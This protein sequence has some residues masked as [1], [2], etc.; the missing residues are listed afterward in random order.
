MTMKLLLIIISI[1]SLLLANISYGVTDDELRKLIFAAPVFHGLTNEA[2]DK[3]YDEWTAKI[4]E[5]PSITPRV[6]ELL[7][8]ENDED[9]I[10]Y[11]FR[12]LRARGDLKNDALNDLIAEVKAIAESENEPTFRECSF[13]FG[14]I[15]LLKKSLPVKMKC[16]C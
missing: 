3:K 16:F 13:A 6:I 1:Y 9:K 2:Q 15:S 5:I 12:A 7:H 14:V 8:E 11:Y 4:R 10:N